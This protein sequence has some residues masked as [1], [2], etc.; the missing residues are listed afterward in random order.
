MKSTVTSDFVP[1]P[2]A[3]AGLPENTPVLLALSGGADSRALLHLLA[4]QRWERD[5]PLLLAH[6]DHGIRGEEA[7]RDCAFCRSLA[8]AYG[9]ELCVRQIDVPA[10]AAESGRGLEEEAR[11]ARYAFFEELMQERKIPILVTAHHGDDHL[12]TVLFRMAR[13][14]GLRGLG[15]IAPVRPF[16]N[17]WLVRP[18]LTRSRAEILDYCQQ[19]KLEY[20]TDSTNAQEC[21]ARNR[22]R[23]QIVPALESLFDRPQHRVLRMSESLREDEDCL[24]GL[25]DAFLR[26]HCEDGVLRL[27]ELES[28]HP[29][30]RKRVWRQWVKALTHREPETV[31]VDALLALSHGETAL[32][33]GFVALAENGCVRILGEAQPA[34][35][36]FCV[37]FAEGSLC[38]DNGVTLRVTKGNKREEHIKINNLSTATHINVI[39]VSDIMLRTLFWRSRE[40]GDVIKMGGM[41]RKLRK[42]YNAAKIPPRMREQM[43]LLCDGEGILWAPFIGLRDHLPTDNGEPYL[44]EVIF[45]EASK[46]GNT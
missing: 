13:G 29:A 44:L 15:G 20:V 2:Q 31:H 7:K 12:E 45:N 38:L 11:A 3:L 42:L 27:R 40:P 21:Y 18:M 33:G 26:E 14:T 10:M 16:A 22:V 4:A 1:T 32:P 34:P 43:P 28:L 24:A 35:Q 17:G 6:V 23:G 41:H 36:P 8:D 39:A 37:P 9:L 19:N 46:E 25:A 5:F 30:V